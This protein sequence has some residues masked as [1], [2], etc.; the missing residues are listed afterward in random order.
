MP[1]LFPFQVKYPLHMHSKTYSSLGIV[2]CYTSTLHS[3]LM[4]GSME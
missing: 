2:C 4:Q 1:V 3:I